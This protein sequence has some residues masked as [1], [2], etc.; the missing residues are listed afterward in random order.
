MKVDIKR[1]ED[2]VL[3]ALTEPATWDPWLDD[4]Y[5]DDMDIVGHTNP[6]Y[7]LFYLLALEFKPQFSVE[8]GTY[9]AVAAGHLAA[10]NP[11]GTVYT[12]DWHRDAGDKKH[13]VF[14]IGMDAHYGNVRYINGCSWSP[15][16]VQQ[17]AVKASKTPI[18]FLFIDAWHWYVHAMREWELYSPLL[19]DEALVVCDDISDNP[20]STV[21]MVRF[22]EE[23]SSGYERFTNTNLH[24]AVRMGFF[25]FVRK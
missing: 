17:V 18:D 16:V 23:V 15:D 10:G 7:K 20:G 19:A 1:V 2:L 11:H 24:I 8:L 12:I 25:R 9:R 4:R 3:E 22:W 5:M 13:Q 14:A 21:D 6:Y